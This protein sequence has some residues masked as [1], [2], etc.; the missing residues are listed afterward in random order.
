M[1]LSANELAKLQAD[2]RSGRNPLA[3]IPICNELRRCKR[4]A[5]ALEIC[6][7]GLSRDPSSLAGRIILARLLGDLGRYQQALSE[8]K[9]V[10]A[11]APD[12]KGLL[13]EKA[14]CQ[15]KLN[16]LAEA[17][18]TLT[19]L[20]FHNPVD[21]EVQKIRTQFRNVRLA[22]S[23]T[24][25]PKAA[26]T[27]TVTLSMD[28]VTSLIKRQLT[29]LGKLKTVALLDLDSGRSAIEGDAV[30]AD[31]GESLYQEAAMACDELDQGLLRHVIVEIKGALMIVARRDRKL[32]VVCSDPTVNF[33]KLQHRLQL[34]LDQHV[35]ATEPA[36][37]VG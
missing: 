5:E 34:C 6:Q 26:R 36:T 9:K 37:E 32:V 10:E 7:Q 16:L 28:E 17:E 12:S 23:Q 14:R 18:E 25:G 4:N 21:P 19:N 13:I 22:S 24:A 2:L 31:A 30:F 27:L 20:E 8:V 35:P 29:P 11:S 1:A 15:V 33:G 3:Y